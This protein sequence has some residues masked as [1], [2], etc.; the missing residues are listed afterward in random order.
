[1]T[2][3][4]TGKHLSNRLLSFFFCFWGVGWVNSVQP[5]QKQIHSLYKVIL[6]AQHQVSLPLELLQ[7]KE[8]TK[9]LL[10]HLK[11]GYH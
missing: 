10:P 9:C 6:Q 11:P 1:M 8:K 3:R 5:L 2:Y 4:K 7:K